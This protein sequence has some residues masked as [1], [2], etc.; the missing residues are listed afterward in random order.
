MKRSDFDIDYLINLYNRG[1]PIQALSKRFGV[2]RSTLKRRFVERGVIIR[3]NREAQTIR[4]SRTTKEDRLRFS[5]AAH[6]AVRGSKRPIEEKYKTAITRERKQLGISPV[7]DICKRM[8]EERGFT[9][10][11]QKAIGPYNID[12]ALTEFSI[13]V[14]IF[15]GGWHAQGRVSARFSKRVKYLLDSDWLPVIIWVDSRWFPFGVGAVDYIVSLVDKISSDKTLR[16]KKH[17]IRG[18]GEIFTIRKK[19]FND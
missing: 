9:C 11:S 15:G 5:S 4:M 10:K 17:M 16:S 6:A 19:E 8:L 18:D 13:A 1:E 2:S 3:G 7:E 14:E 12:I